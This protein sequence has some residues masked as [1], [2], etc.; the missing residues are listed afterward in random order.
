MA[1]AHC[2]TFYGGRARHTL[3]VATGL[4]FFFIMRRAPRTRTTTMSIRPDRRGLGLFIAT[5]DCV[6]LIEAEFVLADT[7]TCKQTHTYTLMHTHT[8]KN[9]YAHTFTHTRTHAYVAGGEV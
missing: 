9:T 7:H 3:A 4:C 5:H 8:C 2:C 6:V 1:T